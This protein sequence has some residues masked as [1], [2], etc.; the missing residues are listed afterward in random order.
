MASEIIVRPDA[1]GRVGLATLTKILR[2]QFTGRPISGY[3]AEITPD[4][5]IVLRPRVEVDA[6]EAATLI[7]D[8][9]DRDAFLAALADPPVP[10]D[11]LRA[12]VQ[13]HGRQV[14]D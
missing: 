13:R 4:G 12:A 1:K 7:L 10:N 9:S 14:K 8:D 2:E 6:A 11:R 3:A 5:A